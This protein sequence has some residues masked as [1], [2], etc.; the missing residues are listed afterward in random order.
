MLVPFCPSY[1]Y[2]QW[3]KLRPVRLIRFSKLH[4]NFKLGSLGI[5]N[6][7]ARNVIRPNTV[8][9]IQIGMIGGTVSCLV[10]AEYR[11]KLFL[12]TLALKSTALECVYKMNIMSTN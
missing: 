6:T 5:E 9:Q 10:I 11:T 12:C 7:R 1:D 8:S 3:S 2:L 4:I